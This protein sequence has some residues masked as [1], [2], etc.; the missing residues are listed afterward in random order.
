MFISPLFID[1]TVEEEFPFA[2]EAIVPDDTTREEVESAMKVMAKVDQER[3]GAHA[4]V[5]S[6]VANADVGEVQP[7]LR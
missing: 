7:G 5:A 3:G 4:R 2:L 1:V 6:P